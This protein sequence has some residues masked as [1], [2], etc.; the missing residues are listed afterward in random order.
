MRDLA[1]YSRMVVRITSRTGLAKLSNKRPGCLDVDL[2]ERWRAHAGR[3]RKG[4]GGIASL[5]PGYGHLL[6]RG[7]ALGAATLVFA[8]GILLVA[9]YVVSERM[10]GF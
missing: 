4:S 1:A 6:V 8:F 2:D 9:G 10:V 3:D 7:A 5:R